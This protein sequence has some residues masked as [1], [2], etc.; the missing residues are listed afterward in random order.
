MPLTYSPTVPLSTIDAAYLKRTYLAGFTFI[1][2]DT[3]QE[4]GDAF[5]EE[6]LQNALATLEETTGVDV[7]ERQNVGEAHDFKRNDY[8]GWGFIPL[9]RKPCRVITELR[10]RYVTGQEQVVWPSTWIRFEAKGSLLQIVPMAGNLGQV[11]IGNGAPIP[12]VL[13][14][15]Y[16]PHFWAVDYVSG[17]DPQ[18]VPR[19]VAEALAKLA[20]VSALS[21]L[22][23]FVNPLGVGGQSVSVDGLSQSRSFVV[24]AFKAQ[25]DQYNAD[26][27]GAPGFGGGLIEQI[28]NNYFG[29]SLVGA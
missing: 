1:D 13:W 27:N 29:I 23:N 7:L 15:S 3:Q 8:A 20:A 28:R 9:F 26:L 19:I 14:G 16:A 25:I 10:V 6:H 2:D 18:K 4:V 12:A 24:P 17:F 22:T 11:M 5:Y 21:T